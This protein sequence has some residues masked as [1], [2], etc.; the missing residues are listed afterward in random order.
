MGVGDLSGLEGAGGEP[1]VRTRKQ[2]LPFD[3]VT[4]GML[5]GEPITLAERNVVRFSLPAGHELTENNL[6]QLA[7]HH[8]EFVCIAVPDTRSDAQIAEDAAAAARRVMQIFEGADLANPALAA[9]FDR[10]LTYRSR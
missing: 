3:E 1:P 2:Y 8:A 4:A 5:L 6:R 9:L 7:V 10:V